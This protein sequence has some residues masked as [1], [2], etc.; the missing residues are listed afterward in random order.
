VLDKKIGS[1]VQG[2]VYRAISSKGKYYAVKVTDMANFETI[3]PA[4][5]KL[6]FRNFKREIS[7]MGSLDHPNIIK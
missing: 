4:Q 1:G 3:D 2:E 5:N 7:I 6:N